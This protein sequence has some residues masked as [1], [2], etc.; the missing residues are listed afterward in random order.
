[1]ILNLLMHFNIK[2]RYFY[3]TFTNNKIAIK[4]HWE[5]ENFIEIL[6]Q[7]YAGYKIKTSFGKYQKSLVLYK[8]APKGLLATKEISISL[9]TEK[10][11]Y[12]LLNALNFL[13]PKS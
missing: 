7:E 12:N 10:D 5:T 9:L 2:P 4:T 3:C 13:K 6:F 8:K 1:M 11:L